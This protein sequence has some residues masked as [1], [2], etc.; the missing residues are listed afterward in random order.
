M[1]TLLWSC[2]LLL[3]SAFSVFAN[4]VHPQDLIRFTDEQ[5]KI[6]QWRLGTTKRW[7]TFEQYFLK[8]GQKAF[9]RCGYLY[10]LE[11]EEV[12]SH[13]N[14][15]SIYEEIE[16]VLIDQN[17]QF[18]ASH[19]EIEDTFNIALPDKKKHKYVFIYFDLPVKKNGNYEFSDNPNFRKYLEKAQAHRQK[20]A[21]ILKGLKTVP[22]YRI[23][24]PL[25]GF[26]NQQF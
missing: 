10:D 24:I 14:A 11:S 4:N 23:E 22:W 13:D 17:S 2:L 16:P 12:L 1:K 9:Y 21:T 7:D 26:K 19:S 18:S 6:E 15:I 8:K 20:A 25:I 3:A 5:N